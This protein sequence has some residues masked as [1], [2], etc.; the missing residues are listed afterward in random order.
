MLDRCTFLWFTPSQCGWHQFTHVPLGGRSSSLWGTFFNNSTEVEKIGPLTPSHKRKNLHTF[1]S[2]ATE[3]SSR[4]KHFW[5]F[6]MTTAVSKHTGTDKLS[7]KDQSNFFLQWRK[8]KQTETGPTFI[9][10]QNHLTVF[11]PIALKN[12]INTRIRVTDSL[13]APSAATNLCLWTVRL[14]LRGINGRVLWKPKITRR[15]EGIMRALSQKSQTNL[16]RATVNRVG[17]GSVTWHE[18]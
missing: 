14:P 10:V 4:A 11:I 12:T 2:Q 16:W 17:G 15:G 8:Q 1:H 18:C 6:S 13:A 5:V 9:H 7:S 3:T